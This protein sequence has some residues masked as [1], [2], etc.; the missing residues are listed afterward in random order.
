[1]IGQFAAG[2][3]ERNQP[4]TIPLCYLS[5]L[6]FINNFSRYR[7]YFVLKTQMQIITR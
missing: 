7:D 3:S 4:K 1:M 2:I 5:S 6:S